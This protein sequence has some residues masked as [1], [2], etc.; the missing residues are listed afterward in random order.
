M[1]CVCAWVCGVW[2]S[3]CVRGCVVCVW[4]VDGLGL[5]NVLVSV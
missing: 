3:V 4:G 2:G 1:E 5:D